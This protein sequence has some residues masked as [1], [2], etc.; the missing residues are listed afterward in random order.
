[1]VAEA[2]TGAGLLHWPVD[3]VMIVAATPDCATLPKEHRERARV[4]SCRDCERAVVYCIDTLQDASKMNRPVRFF[5]QDCF[6]KYD[7]RTIG[8]TV[9]MRF[10]GGGK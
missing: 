4:G 6:L 8:I 2:W 7:V 1:M 9:E 5:C 10:V 3:A